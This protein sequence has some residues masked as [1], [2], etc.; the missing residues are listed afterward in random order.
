MLH[1]VACAAVLL[2]AAPLECQPVAGNARFIPQF[3]AVPELRQ[4]PPDNQWWPGQANDANAV[5]EHNGVHHIMFQTEC[6]ARDAAPGGICEGGVIGAHAFSHLVSEDGGARWRR[7]ADA[8]SPTPNSGY[9][10]HDGDCDGTISF[11]EGIGPVVLWGADCGTGKWPPNPP[12]DLAVAPH[13][14]RSRRDYP[15][16]AVAM[17][18]ASDPHLTRWVKSA[19]NP[20]EW[21]DPTMPCSFPGRVWQ[22]YAGGKMHWSMVGTGATIAPKPTTQGPWFRYETTDPTLH[23]PWVLADADFATVNGNAF[24]DIST[25][26]FYKLP[27]PRKGEPTHIIN[28]GYQGGLYRMAQFD[29]VTEKLVNVS[30]KSFLVSSSWAVSGQSE[31]D[32]AILNVAWVSCQS[33]Q[34]ASSGHGV[35]FGLSIM[36]A[37]KVISYDRA[38]QGLVSNPL[39]AYATLRNGTFVNDTAVRTLAPGERYSPALTLLDGARGTS[40]AQSRNSSSIDSTGST[41]GAAVDVLAA[42]NVPQ[43]PHAATSFELQ[44]LAATRGGVVNQTS[45]WEI[46]ATSLQFNISAADEST[47]TRHGTV[48]MRMRAEGPYTIPFDVLKGE[49]SIT[50]R[51]L[52]DRSVVE[53][54]VQG[55]RASTV[56]RDYN[57]GE[58]ETAIHITNTDGAALDIANLT[59]YSMGCGWV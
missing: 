41:N 32:G 35:M 52:V 56:A 8:L 28:A 14:E 5:F 36:S 50:V 45:K 19:N 3:H 59:V 37:V 44:V 26:G 57:G 2:P 42:V 38:W 12:S 18:N 21:A 53:V 34:P 20:I 4:L 31:S 40:R 23:G 10:S 11:P 49:R 16:V 7:L 43:D 29:P 48:T 25:P 33:G 46:N 17:G 1:L 27:L 58:D 54:F 39:P 51:V 13:H 24:G 9:D 15:R 6:T 30:S 55:G 47:G 22:S